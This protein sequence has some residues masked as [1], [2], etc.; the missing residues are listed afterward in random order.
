MAVLVPRPAMGGKVDGFIDDL[1]KVFVDTPKNCARQP[2]VVPLAMYVTSRPHAGTG[3]EAV[4]RRPILSLPKLIAEGRPEEVQTVLGWNLDTRRLKISLPS[5]KYH[6][7]DGGR[8]ERKGTWALL[9]RRP[10]DSCGPT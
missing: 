9:P 3:A 10:G 4:P 7:W 6:T 8:Q 2:D 1:I 5:D